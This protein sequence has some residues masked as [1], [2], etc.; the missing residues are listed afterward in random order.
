MMRCLHDSMRNILMWVTIHD[1]FAS[2]LGTE[3]NWNRLGYP[4]VIIVRLP[5]LLYVEFLLCK[6][7]FSIHSYTD[8]IHI[9]TSADSDHW[10]WSSVPDIA[11]STA[12]FAEES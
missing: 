5:L 3:E 8:C 12:N 2:N 10:K 11:Q 7:K 9:V 1:P 6:P 4:W